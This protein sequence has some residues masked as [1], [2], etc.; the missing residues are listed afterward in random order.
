MR[1]HL[2]RVSSNAFREARERDL[3]RAA[4]AVAG[5]LARY[6]FDNTGQVRGRCSG[7]GSGQHHPL[8]PSFRDTEVSP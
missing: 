4:W 5:N 7:H 8:C 6:V 1:R 2:I 3:D